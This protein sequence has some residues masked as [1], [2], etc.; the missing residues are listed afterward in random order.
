MIVSLQVLGQ[1]AFDFRLSIAQILVALATSAVIEVCV[2]FRRQRV[3]MWPASALLTGNGVAFILRVPGTEHGDWWSMQG[4]WIFAGTAAVAIGSKYV[5]RFRRQHVFNPSNFGLVLCFLVLGSERAEPLDFWWGPMSPSLVLALAIIVAGG[6][7]ILLRLHLL[8]VAIGF[9][10]AFA[11]GI[12]VLAASGHAM[13]A[14]WHLGPISDGYF[15]S[16][17]V[18][19]P[20]VLVFL[21]FMITDPKTVPAGRDARLTFGVAVGL[22]A[23][24]LIAPQTTEFGTKV[25]LLAALTL[26]CAARPLIA[27]AGSRTD[28]FAGALRPVK[29]LGL[30]GP[31]HVT[32]GT[33]ALA[34]GVAY[35]GLLVVAG[36]PARTSAAASAPVQDASGLPAVIIAPS[37][38]GVSQI[39]RRTA[40]RIARDVLAD[41]RAEADA[42]RRQDRK[43]A[44]TGADDVW[45][46]QLRGQI[47]G[48]GGVHVVPVY[49]VERMRLSLERGDGQ[50]PPTIVATLYGTVPANHLHWTANDGAA[51]LRSVPLPANR[52]ARPWAEPLPD[53]PLPRWCR[54]RPCYV[55]S[56]E[57]TSEPGS[58]ARNRG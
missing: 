51:T 48:A 6:F 40:Q 52:R 10:V 56:H 49:R 34:V 11:A 16:V 47:T 26:V 17:L 1:V 54:R 57:H 53:R 22:L 27:L 45:L 39:D 14:R 36:I 42:L 25:A 23:T 44:A 43:L 18:F 29:Q 15:W 5:I 32:V 28:W 55:G 31:T 12:G 37:Q 21:F 20:E 8:V 7:A 33:I 35:A 2:A 46:G 3:I 24:L 4:A 9:W 41:L 19:S 38:G 58:L 13:T 30:G 50:A